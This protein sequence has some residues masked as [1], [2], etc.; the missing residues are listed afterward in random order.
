MLGID[1]IN[2]Y[3]FKIK[4]KEKTNENTDDSYES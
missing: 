4:F 2:I 3:S 1:I